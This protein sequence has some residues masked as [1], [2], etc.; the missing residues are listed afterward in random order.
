MSPSGRIGRRAATAR[1]ARGREQREQ[2]GERRSAATSRAGKN[3]AAATATVDDGGEAGVDCTLGETCRD[4]H[5][6]LAP[7]GRLV[8]VRLR[9]L[10]REALGGRGRRRGSTRARGR[11]PQISGCGRSGRS[12]AS[13]GAPAPIS[14]AVSTGE[15]AKNG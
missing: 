12:L 11:P 2:R 15:A 13:E 1:P 6:S 5:G 3:G 8:S 14:R 9:E 7:L 4:E 10:G